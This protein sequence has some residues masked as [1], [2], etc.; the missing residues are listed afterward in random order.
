MKG[1]LRGT[2]AGFWQAFRWYNNCI[3][4]IVGPAIVGGASRVVMGGILEVFVIVE[5]VE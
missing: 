1:M 5:P 3:L 2:L 4:S